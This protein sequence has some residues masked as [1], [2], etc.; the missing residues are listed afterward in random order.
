[1]LEP[2]SALMSIMIGIVILLG[3]VTDMQDTTRCLVTAL[4]FY[5][6]IQMLKIRIDCQLPCYAYVKVELSLALNFF[7]YKGLYF[8][9][10]NLFLCGK[11]LSQGVIEMSI[12]PFYNV[13][14]LHVTHTLEHQ[15]Y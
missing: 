2:V 3:T 14:N 9:Y 4:W 12:Q 6:Y 13:D 1:M 8:F 11:N 15:R 7:S 10:I 5:Q